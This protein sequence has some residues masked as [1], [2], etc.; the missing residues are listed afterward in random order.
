MIVIEKKFSL[1]PEQQKRL[2]DGAELISEK[3]ISDTYF[4]NSKYNLTTKDWWLRKRDG[5]FELKVALEGHD[6]RVINQYDEITD[7]NAIRNKLDLQKN[8]SLDEDL[9]TAGYVPFIS[10]VT[11]RHK[12]KK[13]GFII[14]LDQVDY[15]SDFKYNLAEIEAT[16]DDSSQRQQAIDS[17]LNFA[18]AHNLTD[19]PVHGKTIEY[20][21]QKRPKHYKAL[22]D[23]GVVKE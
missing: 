16:F 4:D 18:K 9:V 11:T 17:I 8:A 5:S 3:Q 21:I 23:A 20:L 22:V 7:E 12:Y 19:E 14:D 6:M 10:M 13:D 15:D 2:L 1:S